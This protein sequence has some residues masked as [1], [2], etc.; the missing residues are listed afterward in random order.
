MPSAPAQS[1]REL[2]E[3]IAKLAGRQPKLQTL[4]P[5]MLRFLSLFSPTMRELKE[6]LFI[7]DRPYRIDHEKFARRFWSDFT[8]LEEGLEKTLAWYRARG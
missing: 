1:H 5:K 7:W 6:M 3:T 8:P 4:S 2:V